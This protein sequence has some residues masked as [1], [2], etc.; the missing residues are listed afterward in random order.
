MSDNKPTG[1]RCEFHIV[2]LQRPRRLS[3]RINVSYFESKWLPEALVKDETNVTSIRS[4]KS[5][6]LFVNF[7]LFGFVSSVLCLVTGQ[8]IDLMAALSMKTKR[9]D[10]RWKRY[11]VTSVFIAPVSRRSLLMDYRFWTF[12][13]F[14]FKQFFLFIW[15]NILYMFYS[16]GPSFFLNFFLKF[17]IPI[18]IT[19]F[20]LLFFFC[21]NFFQTT[22]HCS[23]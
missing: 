12:P 4:V 5:S 10:I 7:Y 17:A 15:P 2:R 22:Y 16:F 3:L 11:L 6:Y 1:T 21:P 9:E 19:H 13:P 20:F 23:T 14:F 8:L 18:F